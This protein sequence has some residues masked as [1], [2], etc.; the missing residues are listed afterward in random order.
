MAMEN[1]LCAQVVN[2][3]RKESEN[4]K[5]KDKTKKYNLQGKSARKNIG[6]IL[7]MSD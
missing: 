3:H 1:G 2:I 7:I 5:E 4:K 6:S